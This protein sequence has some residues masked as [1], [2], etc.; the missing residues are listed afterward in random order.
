M[1][2]RTTIKQEG[3]QTFSATGI[4][5]STSDVDIVI[6]FILLLRMQAAWQLSKI[7]ALPLQIDKS[8]AG[9]LADLP[10]K[11]VSRESAIIKRKQS[12]ARALTCSLA[13]P[14]DPNSEADHNPF[15]ILCW[16]C[17][18]QAAG[19][20]AKAE[21]IRWNDQRT[22]VKALRTESGL[23]VGVASLPNAPQLPDKPE[24]PFAAMKQHLVDKLVGKLN[25]SQ[26][27]RGSN[28]RTAGT[29]FLVEFLR[30]SIEALIA[31]LGFPQYSFHR[32]CHPACLRKRQRRPPQFSN[33]P[34]PWPIPNPPPWLAGAAHAR[35]PVAPAAAGEGREAGSSSDNGCFHTGPAGATG[36]AGQ[37]RR[38]THDGT[39]L[40]GSA[41]FTGR[42]TCLGSQGEDFPCAPQPVLSLCA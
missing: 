16:L 3:S 18:D 8:A 17:S 33:S 20:R 32:Q 6:F 38:F 39:P 10:A 27:R 36:P 26:T 12:L 42:K 9:L 22:N 19:C 15:C 30:N 4:L 31:A 29:P 40:Q 5:L 37:H 35:S 1:S 11:L 21:Y 2:R 41:T 7:A 14:M 25:S 24:L 13:R 28:T 34:P 23:R